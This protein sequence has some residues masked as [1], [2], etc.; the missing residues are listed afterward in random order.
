MQPK[1]THKMNNLPNILREVG[2]EEETLWKSRAIKHLVNPLK[3]KIGKFSSN[4]ELSHR[5]ILI[6]CPQFLP[7]SLSPVKISFIKLCKHK[8]RWIGAC[9]NELAHSMN[10]D[11]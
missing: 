9:A 10:T 2:K 11:K 4:K 3:L 5:I 8:D 7:Q 1:L 6:S